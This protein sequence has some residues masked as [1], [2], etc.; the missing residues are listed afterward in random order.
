[1][2]GEAK[3]NHGI[4][5][6]RRRAQSCVGPAGIEEPEIA[7]GRENFRAMRD[8][9]RHWE[10]E[11]DAGELCATMSSVERVGFNRRGISTKHP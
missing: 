8:R 10:E 11:E 1:M 6:N 4:F 9:V 7:Q 3:S 5:Q 2:R